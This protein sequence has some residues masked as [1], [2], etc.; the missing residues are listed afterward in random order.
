MTRSR[1]RPAPARHAFS[2]LELMLVVA[3]MGVL[4]AVVGF[5]VIGAGDRAK[6]RATEATIKNVQTALNSYHLEQSAYPP[7]LQIL[8]TT[9]VLDNI[10]LADGWGTPL[11][12][13]P[14]ATSE[15]QPFQLGSAGPDKNPGSADD[16]SVW[17]INR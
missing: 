9:K 7:D 5:N 2:L 3:I 4:M 1:T 15:T 6:K 17:N 16:I 12:Y 11:I 8:I 14:Q 13:N 10:K